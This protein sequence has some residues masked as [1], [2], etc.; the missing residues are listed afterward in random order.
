[1]LQDCSTNTIVLKLAQS[2]P[3]MV[4]VETNTG[5]LVFIKKID[6]TTNTVTIFRAGTDT[7]E[8]L[9]TQTLSTQNSSLTLIGGG[10]GVWYI[11][12]N[13]PKPFLTPRPLLLYP[14]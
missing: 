3:S 9:P 5:M 8:S 14:I 12:S 10:S 7:I 6:A 1:M 13:E 4:K 11:L 2:L